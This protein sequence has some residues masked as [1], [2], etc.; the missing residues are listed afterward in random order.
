MLLLIAS[1]IRTVR[2]K[3]SNKSQSID[4]MTQIFKIEGMNCNHCR[5][6]VEKAISSVNG[7]ENVEVSL[8][9]KNAVVKGDFDKDNIMEAVRLAGFDISC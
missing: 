4:E 8:S 6:S 3:K 7:V 9:Q 1:A 2:A 5:A